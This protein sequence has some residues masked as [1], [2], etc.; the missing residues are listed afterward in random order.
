M[1]SQTMT[2]ANMHRWLSRI[3]LISVLTLV[4]CAPVAVRRG[5]D[6]ALLQAQAARE[7][8]LASMPDWSLSGRIAVSDGHDGGSGRIE[9]SQHG[10]DFDIRLS[11][12]IT[13][14]SWRLVRQGAQVRLEG[15]DGGALEGDDAQALL[16]QALG[17]V[18]PVD[19]L[20][21]WV[22]GARAGSGATL[23]FDADG[24]PALLDEQGWT[25]EY[26]AWTP[27]TTL[28]LPKKVFASQGQ[29]RVRLQVDRWNGNIDG[30]A[31][32]LDGSSLPAPTID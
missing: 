15:L 5:P 31:A 13:R 4:A 6:V 3:A 2:A 29:S 22:R 9:W 24:L 18:I 11:A 16:Q 10:S 14:R 1:I 32:P 20:A 30:H 12:P 26:R 27:D 25:V 19:A 8:L 23:E 28:A 21:A 7:A 17:W